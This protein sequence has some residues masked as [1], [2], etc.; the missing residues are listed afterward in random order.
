MI[1]RLAA[2]YEIDGYFIVLTLI[3]ISLPF[4][5]FTLS[6][7]QFVLVFL[8]L[9]DGISW[10][11]L[12][13]E[14][15]QANFIKKSIFHAFQA[16]NALVGNLVRKLK[17]FLS[18][19]IAV[20][21]ASVYLLHVVGLI[22]TTDFG[23][24]WKDLRIKL[25]LLL[26]PLI[27]STMP[28]LNAQKTNVLMGF[29][30]A[31]VSTGTLIS[32]VSYLQKD[33]NDIRDISL[34]ISP[35]RFSLMVVFSFL[36]L[37]LLALRKQQKSLLNRILLLLLA[38]WLFL[39]LVILESIIGMLSAVF[40]ACFLLLR[41]ALK[42]QKTYTRVVAFSLFSGLIF[43]AGWYVWDSFEELTKRPSIDISTLD[44]YSRLG[45]EY[46]HDTTNFGVEDGKFV[47]IYFAEAE[48]AEAWNK[49]SQYDFYGKDEAGQL[50]MYT[51]IR[52]LTSVDLRKDADGVNQL[53]TEDIRFIERGIAN[54]RYVTTP[55]LKNRLSKIITGY[56][57]FVDLNDPSGNSIM[58]RVEH[59]KASKLLI[60]E[61]FWLGVGTG[62][63]PAAFRQAYD[64][65][66][67]KLLPEL[68]WRSHNQYVS[69]MVAF[70]IFGFV[71]FMFSLFYPAIKSGR[72]TNDF[73]LVFF[74]LILISML[75]EDTI[76]TQIGVS[77][78][79]FF[80][81]FFVLTTP[82]QYHPYQVTS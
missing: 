3:A 36:M 24:A 63:M 20:V 41:S 37:L 62:D 53:K 71:W 43:A 38:G 40:I 33:F 21:L 34:F 52:Y 7:F 74:L 45:N 35:V 67:S 18:N 82:K 72:L 60:Q 5:K 69:M 68:R 14:K 46:R 66:Q 32:F 50:I 9:K 80:Y 75:S 76:E 59:L 27:L 13:Q 22:T 30:I 78:I 54:K 48:M 8:W 28:R 81:S 15:N 29:F 57:S 12:S 61:N 47:G 31:A 6:L 10:P 73:F 44:K 42:N 77:L 79:S 25:P 64:R 51:V 58:Q 16:L 65:M 56:E 4:S 17:L 11:A 49:R 1:R 55:G 23:Y 70:G 39:Y 2:H 19:R 26:F